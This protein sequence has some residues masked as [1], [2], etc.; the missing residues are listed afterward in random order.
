MSF[1]G[2]ATFELMNKTLILQANGRYG[3]PAVTPSGIMH[4][5]GSLDLS[6]DKSLKDGKWG[7]GMRFT[8]VFNTQGMR[9]YLDQPSVQQYVEFKWLT[10]R[11]YVSLRYR[12]GKVDLD[13]SKTANPSGNNGGGGFDL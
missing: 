5:R 6:A 3:L 12:F 11:V 2:S 8:D 7:I 4:P 13:K 9:F 10:R 1:K